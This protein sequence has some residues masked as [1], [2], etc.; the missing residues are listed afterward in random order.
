MKQFLYIHDRLPT[1]FVVNVDGRTLPVLQALVGGLIDV[2]VV[3]DPTILSDF[4]PNLPSGHS[5]DIVVNDEGLYNS[6]FKFNFPVSDLI[7]TG[8]VGPAVVTLSDRASGDTVG[9]P[10]DM[11]THLRAEFIGP[12]VDDWGVGGVDDNGGA[13]WDHIDLLAHVTT[14]L[15]KQAV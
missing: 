8:L 12:Y 11:L 14:L 15:D 5:V 3:S 2:A 7:G 4:F 13:G 1:A 10:S 6:D 9:L